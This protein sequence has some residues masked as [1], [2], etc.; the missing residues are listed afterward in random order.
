MAFTASSFHLQVYL[1]PKLTPVS[2]RKLVIVFIY[3]GVILGSLSV[4]PI[5]MSMT[6]H[7]LLLLFAELFL[8]PSIGFAGSDPATE[9]ESG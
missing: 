7:S 6:S 4:P 9:P 1:M 3:L 2:L 8:L 5:R